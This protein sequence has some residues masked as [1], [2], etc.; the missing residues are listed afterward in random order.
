MKDFKQL[1][2][3]STSWCPDCMRAK[4]FLDEFN[5][6]YEMIDIDENPDEAIRLEKETGKRAVP[7]FLLDGEWIKPYIPGQGFLREEMRKL[8]EV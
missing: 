2:V 4:F 1:K 6:P 5:I 3:Y 8:F 7:H